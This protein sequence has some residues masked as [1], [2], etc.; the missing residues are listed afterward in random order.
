MTTSK[1]N[2]KKDLKTLGEDVKA[3]AKEAKQNI[4]DKAK[5]VS[6][7]LKNDDKGEDSKSSEEETKNDLKSFGNDIKKTAQETGKDIE[8]EA[9]GIRDYFKSG[10]AK[11]DLKSFGND[12]KDY[13]KSDK[14]NDELKS[15]QNDIY[16]TRNKISDRSK[17]T[18]K[19]I[20]DA[21]VKLEECRKNQL[22]HSNEEYNKAADK[23]LV[24]LK[25]IEDAPEDSV[26]KVSGDCSVTIDQAHNEL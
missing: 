26:I 5:K 13:F 19:N 7:A 6:D 22:S 23:F 11:N 12:V 2:F 10:E 1:D 14:G 16:L 9:K 20:E 3:G 17:D 18:K 24:S 15:L 4:K 21:L 8:G 25:A